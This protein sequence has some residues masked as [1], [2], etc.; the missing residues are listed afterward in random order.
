MLEKEKKFPKS[1]S[2]RPA[3][4]SIWPYLVP[5]PPFQKV[6]D[7]GPLR[8]PANI[9]TKPTKEKKQ[10]CNLHSIFNVVFSHS[11]SWTC[12]L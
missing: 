7:T 4:K 11:K 8:I 5:R 9:E 12:S 6:C 2:S 1:R 3:P 10:P